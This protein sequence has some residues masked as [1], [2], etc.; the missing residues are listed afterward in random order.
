[1]KNYETGACPKC[2]FDYKKL[3]PNYNFIRV[4]DGLIPREPKDNK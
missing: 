2:G 3:K 4:I 1:M